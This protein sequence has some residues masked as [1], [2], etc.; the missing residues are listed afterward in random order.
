MRNHPTVVLVAVLLSTVTLPISLT[1]ASVALPDIGADLGAGLAP[2]QWVVNGY[3][4]TFASCMLAAG[5]LAD[6]LGRRRVFAVGVAT[7]VVA[8]L[9]SALADD[10]V[11]LDVVRAVAGIGAAA[12][13]TAA[14]A[15][16]AGAFS[17]PARTR[18]FG[19]FGTAIGAGLAFGPSIAGLLIEAFDWRAVFAGPALVGLLVLGLVPLLPPDRQARAVEAGSGAARAVGAG[20]GDAGAGGAGVAGGGRRIDWAG[21]ASFTAALLL[22]IFGFVEGPALG[23]ADPVIVVAFAGSA[24][25]LGVFVLVERRHPEP[26]FDLGLLASPGSSASAWRRA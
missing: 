21:A 1:G 23:W 22:L 7:F 8:G 2:V 26:M 15:L 24:V 25:L 13:G 6:L 4:A 3:N 9:A 14:S 16:L 10:I 17:G 11:L 12:A 18:V 5:A 19:L 20:A